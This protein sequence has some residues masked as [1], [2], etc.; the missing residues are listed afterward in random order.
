MD[1][2]EPLPGAGVVTGEGSRRRHGHDGRKAKGAIRPILVLVALVNL[3]WSLCQLPLIRITESRLCH[4]Y[5]S[6]HDPS[7]IPPH[8][9]VPEHLC[10]IDDVQQAL[11]RIQRVMETSWVAGGANDVPWVAF[12]PNGW[13]TG[14]GR[15]PHDNTLGLAGRAVRETLCA[16]A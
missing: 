9:R 5:Y 13:L 1:D 3:A 14:A 4:D 6:A 2:E 15:L 8:A 11:G 16:V 12:S 10:K 7:V